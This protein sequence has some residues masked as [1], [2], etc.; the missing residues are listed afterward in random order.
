MCINILGSISYKIF[1]ANARDPDWKGEFGAKD[2]E[3]KQNHIPH[4]RKSP[5]KEKEKEKNRNENEYED[6]LLMQQKETALMFAQPCRSKACAL[7]T[8][9]DDW[10][11]LH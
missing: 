3:S 6:H 9:C 10:S 2:V 1:H 5:K 4:L 11:L 8:F 7:P